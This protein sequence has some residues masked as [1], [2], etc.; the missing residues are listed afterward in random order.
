MKLADRGEV[1][2][3]QRR[4]MELLKDATG[5]YILMG[6]AADKASYEASKYGEG[7][8]TYALLNGMRDGQL[9]TEG[10]RLDEGAWF[11]R[12][13][14][15]VPDLAK[16]IGGIQ[17]PV[18]A[19]PFPVVML[20]AEDRAR[21]PLAV[22]KPQ[23]L[24]IA[25]LDEALKDKLQLRTPLREQLRALTYV[26]A[27][28]SWAAEPTVLYLDGD[29]GRVVAPGEVLSDRSDGHGACAADYG[30]C[31]G[32]DR[33]RGA[34]DGP[35]HRSGRVGEGAGGEDCGDGGEGK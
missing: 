35:D 2:P 5:T 3:D 16:T 4:A 32:E 23:L 11:A 27:R 19:A 7:L 14:K 6:S 28:G 34:G 8:L 1:P 22:A 21:I 30:G 12:A 26:G 33:G 9:L 24:R 13:S 31:R 18:I 29:S 17:E 15:D 25:C 20:T 10:S